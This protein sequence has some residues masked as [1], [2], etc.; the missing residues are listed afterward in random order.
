MIVPGMVIINDGISVL[1][2]QHSIKLLPRRT[3]RVVNVNINV[4]QRTLL[5]LLLLLL[6][7]STI[8][9]DV[10]SERLSC[11]CKT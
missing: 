10:C 8:T 5:L 1:R 4:N 9:A 2:L 6:S 3:Y 7:L 11:A